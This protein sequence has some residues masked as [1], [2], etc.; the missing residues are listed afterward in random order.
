MKREFGDEITEITE[1]SDIFKEDKLSK[2]EITGMLVLMIYCW[3]VVLPKY[4][5]DTFSTLCYVQ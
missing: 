2:L 5:K 4:F 1:I 3:N